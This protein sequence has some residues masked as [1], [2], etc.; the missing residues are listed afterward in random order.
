MLPEK[1]SIIQDDH[2]SKITEVH[3][4]SKNR[5]SL[6]KISNDIKTYHVYKN[7]AGQLLFDPQ[8]SIPAREAWIF[9]NPEHLAS[10]Q[11]GLS[12][13][14]EGKIKSRGSF[15]KFTEEEF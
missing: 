3:F 11:R 4:D 2:F 15:A 1:F 8:V 6:G 10:L 7:Q 9:Q 5:V 13:A 14:S 12:Q